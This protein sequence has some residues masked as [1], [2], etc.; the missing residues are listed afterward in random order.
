M[1]EA[2]EDEAR[3][4]HAQGLPRVGDLVIAIGLCVAGEAR[5]QGL[6]AKAPAHWVI[7]SVG[8]TTSWQ[9]HEV[10]SI[11]RVYE[12]YFKKNAID[13][14]ALLDAST[15]LAAKRGLERS[16]LRYL[17]VAFV[18]GT[19]EGDTQRAQTALRVAISIGAATGMRQIFR[20]IAGAKLASSL[21]ILRH[22]QGLSEAEIGFVETLLNRLL[23]R[24]SIAS[25]KLSARELE[26]LRLLESGGSDKRLARQLDLSEHGVRFHLKSIFKKLGVHDRLSAVAAARK[27]NPST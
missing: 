12:L 24:E 26:V 15:D 5:L 6:R 17:L 27:L 18:L 19:A 13:A 2:V 11:A 25:G 8:P 10:F 4:L 16:R 20:E 23:G 1:L 7:P 3:K 9:E 21:Q 14:W 22:E